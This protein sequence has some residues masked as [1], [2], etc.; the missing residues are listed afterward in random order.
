MTFEGVTIDGVN[1]AVEVQ[2]YA[3][4]KSPNVARVLRTLGADPLEVGFEGGERGR[5]LVEDLTRAGIRCDFVNI[6]AQTRLCTTVIDRSNGTATELVEEHAAV[7]PAAWAELDRKLRGLLSEAKMWIFSGSLPPGAPQ[8][9]Y[10]RWVPL[11]REHHATLILDARGQPLQLALAHDGFIAKLN[12]EELAATLGV[13]L[14]SESAL[15]DAARRITPAGGAAI[16]TLGS[17]GAIA[18]DGKRVWQ[19]TAPKVAAISAVGS[20][21]AFAAGLA[22]ELLRGAPLPEALKL[23]SACGAANAMTA[24]AGHV[25]PHDVEDLRGMVSVVDIL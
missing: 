25:R 14:E 10:S 22:L 17:K 15:S 24:L 3:S 2:E 8:D 19:V 11:A 23:A 16:V 13:A 18:S 1:R 7:S 6:P 21:D 5:L 20:G 9:F 12:R 4:G